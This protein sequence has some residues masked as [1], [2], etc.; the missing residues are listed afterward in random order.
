MLNEVAYR[1]GK[2]VG[3]FCKGLVNLY[4]AVR[5]DYARPSIQELHWYPDYYGIENETQYLPPVK[6]RIRIQCEEQI[7]VYQDN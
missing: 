7:A 6:S 1:A 4:K 3:K 2:L 5:E